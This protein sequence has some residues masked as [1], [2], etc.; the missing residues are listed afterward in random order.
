MARKAKSKGRMPPT[1]TDAET[2]GAGPNTEAP[3][4]PVVSAEETRCPTCGSTKRGRY[5]RTTTQVF[6]GVLHGGRVYT[7]I[8]RRW[9][10][11]LNCGQHRIDRV[12]ENRRNNP[13]LSPK[14]PA[15]VA[16]CKSSA[17]PDIAPR[18]PH[19]RRRGRKKPSTA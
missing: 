18:P 9:C 8:V 11:C 10:Q 5:Y 7:H 12:H 3:G 17:P 2:A 1:S 4:T 6:S 16:D 15:S 19:G 14:A 13:E